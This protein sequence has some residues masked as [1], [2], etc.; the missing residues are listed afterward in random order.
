[1]SYI[2]KMGCVNWR[3]FRSIVQYT[4]KN[5]Y[6]MLSPQMSM[7][8]LHHLVYTMVHVLT[9]KGTLTVAVLLGGPENFA[10]QVGKTFD[11][12]WYVRM[13]L[14]DQYVWLANTVSECRQCYF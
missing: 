2:E 13:E 6:V 1:M 9:W 12:A 5:T 10:K 14:S 3:F 4:F 11:S 7:S 8:V